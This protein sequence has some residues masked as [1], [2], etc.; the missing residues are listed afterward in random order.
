MNTGRINAKVLLKPLCDEFERARSLG[1][2]SYTSKLEKM[3]KE[4]D[5]QIWLGNYDKALSI[6][7]NALLNQGLSVEDLTDELEELIRLAC[8]K[9]R[10]NIYPLICY[11]V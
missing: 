9:S 10:K 6:L 2:S 5:N 7:M 4:F 3:C 1:M 11:Y 8:T